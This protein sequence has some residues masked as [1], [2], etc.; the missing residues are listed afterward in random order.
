MLKTVS[1]SDVR[2]PLYNLSG[3]YSRIYGPD[4]VSGD[5]FTGRKV[6]IQTLEEQDSYSID[7]AVDGSL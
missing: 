3:G 4:A 6:I 5:G 1:G 7:D 2:Y